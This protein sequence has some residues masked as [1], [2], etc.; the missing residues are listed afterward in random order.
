MTTLTLVSL[1][2][3]AATMDK[4]ANTLWS[5]LCTLVGNMTHDVA[6]LACDN[7]QDEWKQANPK[8]TA[9]PS[10]WRSAKSVALSALK[11]G[12]ALLEDGKARGK[13]AVEADI[14][15]CKPDTSDMDKVRS[16]LDTL[17]KLYAKLGTSADR[18]EARNLIANLSI[19]LYEEAKAQADTE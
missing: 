4:K 5:N 15:A 18:K 6:V 17:T 19:R 1:I 2:A 7:A 9:L 10:A 3:T 16:T 14:K 11:N 13:S 8:A 12:V